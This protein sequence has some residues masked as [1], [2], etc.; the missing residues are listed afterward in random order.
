MLKK[1]QD[2]QIVKGYPNYFLV[3]NKWNLKKYVKVWK[4][5]EK[6]SGTMS[7]CQSVYSLDRNA[8]NFLRSVKRV[9][10][11]LLLNRIGVDTQFVC[12]SDRTAEDF[13]RNLGKSF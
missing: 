2:N 10:L 9:S 1:Q 5:Q 11:S 12:S 7:G 13:L 4:M 3:Y 6:D 8:A